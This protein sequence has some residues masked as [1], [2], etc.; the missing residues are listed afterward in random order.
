M[1][2]FLLLSQVFGAIF[3]V[4]IPPFQAPDEYV[5]FLRAVHVSRGHLLQ[6]KI[7]RKPGTRVRWPVHANPSAPAY[8]EGVRTLV[9]G[10]VSRAVADFACEAFADIPFN[11]DCPATIS[12]MA[13]WI[14]EPPAEGGDVFVPF[15]ATAVYPPWAYAPAAL[16]IFLADFIT[17]RPLF[18]LYAARLSSL[19]FFIMIVTGALL[20]LPAGRWLLTMVAMTPLLLFVSSCV[21]PDAMLF[22]TGAVFFALILK[23]RADPR[24]RCPIWM[25]AAIV[26]AS[27]AF[28]LTKVAYAP[29]LLTVLLVPM[30][31]LGGRA[32]YAGFLL[33]GVAVN[34]AALLLWRRAT[35]GLWLEVW[36]PVDPHRQLADHVLGDPGHIA[37]V[38]G[39]SLWENGART[40]ARAIGVL[41]W[42]DTRLP[43]PVIAAY[44]AALLLAAC[45]TVTKGTRL[46]LHHR[47]TLIAATAILWLLMALASYL[48]EAPLGSARINPISGRYF[49]PAL[50][51]LLL[52]FAAGRPS[53]PPRARTRILTTVLLLAETVTLL[54][55]LERYWSL[56]PVGALMPR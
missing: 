3:A 39:R 6:E 34:V 30:T 28:S 42:L 17:D 1:L 19:A 41:G 31:K 50:F 45:S 9:G 33:A 36:P 24:P 46:L 56:A 53:L 27:V 14:L 44:G 52:A 10:T 49:L 55:I 35:G 21:S 20:L 5:H 22:A 25:L 7:E 16:G 32:R 26:G 12:E 23:A 18:L 15:P 38:V 4:L 29:L 40:V 48:L 11:P 43:Y 2:V 8:R 51:P 13:H 47:F 37:L 54:I